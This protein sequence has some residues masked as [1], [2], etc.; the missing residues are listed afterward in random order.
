MS[1]GLH[2]VVCIK[3]VR[4]PEAPASSFKV[5]SEN[6]Q[7]TA[8]GVPPVMNPYDESALELAIRMKEKDPEVKISAVAFGNK[9]S[10]PVMMKALAVGADEL[11]LIEDEAEAGG[12]QAAVVLAAAVKKIG[13]DLVLAGRQASDT[14]SGTDPSTTTTV[15]STLEFATS[16]AASSMAVRR[17]DAIAP[18]RSPL[19]LNAP[20]TQNDSENSAT[21]G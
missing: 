15:G 7:I 3:Q 11:Y 12:N 19:T 18:E 13:F 9:L 5:D 2:I 1:E 21:R 4:D 8:E 16:K 6:K 14:N 17:T 20:V 10:R